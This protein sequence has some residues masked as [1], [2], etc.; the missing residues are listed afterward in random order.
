MVYEPEECGGLLWA[1]IDKLPD[2]IIPYVKNVIKDISLNIQY[3]DGS[4]SMQIK[5]E[6]FENHP[7]NSEN[8]EL[9]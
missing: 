3:D 4:F 1:N 2:N 8:I 7:I 9:I 5:K 6:K